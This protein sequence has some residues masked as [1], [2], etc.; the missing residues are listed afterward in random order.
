M[1]PQ[2]L[3]LHDFWECKGNILALAVLIQAY[4]H[5]ATALI[6]RSYFKRFLDTKSHVNAAT[7]H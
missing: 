3:L 1:L 7:W 5:T 6:A 4:L 2:L